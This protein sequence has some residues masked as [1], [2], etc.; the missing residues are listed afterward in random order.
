MRFGT[1]ENPIRLMNDNSK[2]EL[3]VQCRRLINQSAKHEVDLGKIRG[4]TD[5]DPFLNFVMNL[6]SNPTI[7]DSTVRLGCYLFWEH[8]TDGMDRIYDITDGSRGVSLKKVGDHDFLYV[9]NPITGNIENYDKDFPKLCKKIAKVGIKLTQAEC[10]KALIELHEFYYIT[11]TDICYENSFLATQEKGES[12]K[13][14]DDGTKLVHIHLTTAM[15][16]KSIAGKW[17]NR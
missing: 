4:Q 1:A 12:L 17:T 7:A 15:Q 5:S 6:I 13:K 9:G 11:A 8:E 16:N 14:I 2:R 3:I 10:L